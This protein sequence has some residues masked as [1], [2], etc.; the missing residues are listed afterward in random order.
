MRRQAIRLCNHL[1]SPGLP[2]EARDALTF[3]SVETA[4]DV[5]ALA[6]NHHDS[7]TCQCRQVKDVS[8]QSR[9][10][11]SGQLTLKQR[12]RDDSRKPAKQVST[13]IDQDRLQR[14]VS[15]GKG[16]EGRRRGL[17]RGL[18]PVGISRGQ[19]ATGVSGSR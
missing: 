12:L 15:E 16:P 18:R 19:Q 13:T 4:R 6:S 2:L 11:T 10:E 8:R 7:A 1:R 14:R 9:S 17:T 3:V 5:D